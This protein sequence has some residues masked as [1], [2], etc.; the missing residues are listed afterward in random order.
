MV[1]DG[2]GSGGPPFEGGRGAA[3]TALKRSTQAFSAALNS[4]AS[5]WPE[6][7]AAA[8]AMLAQRTSSGLTSPT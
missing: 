7:P 6:A 1:A 8:A 4:A 2:G 5:C 3:W